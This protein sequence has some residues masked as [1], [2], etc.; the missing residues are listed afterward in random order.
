MAH[1]HSVNIGAVVPSR[2][3]SAGGT[4]IDKHPVARIEVRAPGT[5]ASGLGSGV[6][7][8]GIGDRRHHG[9]DRQAMYA[10]AREELDWWAGELGREL[11][12]GVF[13]ENL[14]TVGLEVDASV[15]GTRWTIG[16]AV[17]QVTGPRV[18]C[19][20][21]AGHLGE[22]GW[23]KR[24]SARGRTGAYLAVVAPGVIEPGMPIVAGPAPAHGITVPDVFRALMGD[25]ALARRVVDAEA[26]GESQHSELAAKLRD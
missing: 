19:R 24:F 21:F 12:D 6:V 14:T 16:E 4:A 11:G 25:R 2:H 15:V 18:P 20:T 7:G 26:L 9:G 3:T 17:L 10:V 5:R 8:D 1:V 22:R 13:G 23:V